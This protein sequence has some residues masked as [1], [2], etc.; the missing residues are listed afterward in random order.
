VGLGPVGL[1]CQLGIDQLPVKRWGD[2]SAAGARR[3]AATA[4]EGANTAAAATDASNSSARATST[5]LALATIQQKSIMQL[6]Y[7]QL[8]Y[9][10]HITS[11]SSPANPLKP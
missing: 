1:G 3:Y 8:T 2:R 5:A 10:R 6:T 9:R 11:K 4:T 7:K